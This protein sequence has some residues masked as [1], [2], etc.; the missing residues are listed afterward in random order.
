MKAEVL[1]A[2]CSGIE[3]MAE[4]MVRVGKAGGV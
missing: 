2:A 3:E 4:V 1:N